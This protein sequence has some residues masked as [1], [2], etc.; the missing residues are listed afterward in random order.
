VIKPVPRE[1]AR[2]GNIGCEGV[3]PLGRLYG[4]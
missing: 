2:I 1:S 4:S 3:Y